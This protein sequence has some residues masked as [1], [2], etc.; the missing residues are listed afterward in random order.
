M[1]N[2]RRRIVESARRLLRKEAYGHLKNVLEKLHAADIAI[3]MRQLS[4]KERQELFNLLEP[5]RAAQVLVG[6]ESLLRVEV[7]ESMDSQDI[8]KVLTHLPPDEAVDILDTLPEDKKEELLPLIKKEAVDRLLTYQEE[9]AGRIMT[10]DYLAL[11]EDM[12]VGDAVE[13]VRRSKEKEVF[14]IYVV[15]S[16]GHLVGVLSL[17]QLILQDPK[18]LL[19]DVM[20]SDVIKVRADT[21]QEEVARVVSRYDLLAVPVVDEES[22]LVGV[23]TVDDVIDI[24]HEEATEDIYKMVGASEDELWEAS[25]LKVAGFRLPWLI[26]ALVGEMV[27]GLVIRYYHGTISTFVAVAF[28][29]P[30]IMAL[31]GA[32]GNQ[33]HTI[34]VRAMAMGRTEGIIG[35]I[36]KRQLGV[37]SLLGVIA[38]VLAMALVSVAQGS[39]LLGSAV[40]VSLFVS[41]SVSSLLGVLVPIFFK[42]LNVDPAVTVPSISTLN[43]VM[44]TFIYLTLATYLLTRMR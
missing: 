35:R 21:D 6:M 14:Y 42:K 10:T 37:G 26:F 8:L 7:L 39:L 38:G 11:P 4:R 23:V 30:L 19:K 34:I 44:G 40:G 2:S 33:T 20:N 36:L 29:V 41:M 22:L 24:I 18:S 15:D 32:V 43:D 12:T 16:R 31:A 5:A 27:S 1:N 13:E 28:F 25:I 17:R 9:T 3:L